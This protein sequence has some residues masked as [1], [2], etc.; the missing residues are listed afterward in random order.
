M[1]HT[2]LV[3]LDGSELAE[4]ALP[5]ALSLAAAAR[6]EI[7]LVRVALA[8]APISIEPADF[9]RLQ[10]AEI[11]EAESYL[12]R[13]ASMVAPPVSVKTFVPY[14]RAAHRLV[15]AVREFGADAVVMATHGRTGL[16]H[17]LFGSV[18]EAVLADSP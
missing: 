1:F 7:I 6:G 9:E 8:P 16:P 13:M 5:Y 18:A 15:D 4:R 11:S 3:P 17:L 2:L 12:A 10:R 14:G